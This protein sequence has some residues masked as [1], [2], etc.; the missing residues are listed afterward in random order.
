MLAFGLGAVHA[1]TPG[2]GKSALAAYFFGQNAKFA[3]G[4]RVA[5]TAAMIH[6]AMGFLEF[7]VLRLIVG[8][9]PTMTARGS[10]AFALI[11]YDLILI[12][13][14]IMIYQS[15]RPAELRGSERSLFQRNAMML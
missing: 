8:Q 15:L 11:G 5:L 2:H 1:L 10:P 14:S 12:A 9:M 6:V 7:H 4:I 3:T 13:G